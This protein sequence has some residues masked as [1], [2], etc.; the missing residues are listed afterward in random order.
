M[1][2]RAQLVQIDAKTSAEIPL[3]VE[4][5]GKC[6]VFRPGKAD[7]EVQGNCGFAAA[8][9]CV[10]DGKDTRHGFRLLEVLGFGWV[11]KTGGNAADGF[12]IRSS[13]RVDPLAS[14][15]RRGANLHLITV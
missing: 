14:G 10:S 6:P 12:R 13:I 9:L 4:V 7:G 15:V 5:D 2:R 11:G 3:L 8:A 1:R